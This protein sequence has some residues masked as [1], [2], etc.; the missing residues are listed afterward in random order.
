MF[1]DKFVHARVYKRQLEELRK[2]IPEGDKYRD[3]ELVRV[4]LDLA[5][6]KIKSESESRS[7]V[8]VSAFEAVQKRLD[9][10]E[11]RIEQIQRMLTSI[12]QHV[13][14]IRSN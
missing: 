13:K 3:S 14:N 2:I 4:A 7:N 12:M 11:E 9:I 8:I 5:I 1:R 10:L 6:Q